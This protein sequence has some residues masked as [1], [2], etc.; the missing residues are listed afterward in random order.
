M[1]TRNVSRHSVTGKSSGDG[2]GRVAEFSWTCPPFL[3]KTFE[4][5]FFVQV[6]DFIKF[7]KNGSL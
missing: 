5:G 1:K 7:L 3:R 6:R 2:K 4:G